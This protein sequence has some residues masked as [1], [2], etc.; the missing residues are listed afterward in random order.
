MPSDREALP[1][2]AREALERNDRYLL[3]FVESLNLCP[4]A[5][6]C[7]ETG[8]LHRE[9]L[10]LTEPLVPEVLERIR[11]IEARPPDSI[12][13]ALLLMPNLFIEPKPLERF[14]VSVR[15]AYEAG[16][17]YKNPVP[18]FMVAFHPD[19]PQDLLNADRAVTFIRRSPDP[20]IQLVRA[21]VLDL[22]R[23]RARD[24][25]ELSRVI[26]EAGLE[27]IRAAG[28]E[29]LAQLLQSMRSRRG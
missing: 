22:A 12:E 23:Q 6:T 17:D 19:L 27:A 21:S 25:R 24:G 7:R 2:F 1:L 15:N 14:V 10:A 5:K 9:V 3:E 13:V 20:T 4:Y 29:R 28:P 26:A 18:F 16:R 11:A 8:K